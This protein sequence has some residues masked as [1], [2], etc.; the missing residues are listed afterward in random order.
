MRG[1]TPRL[2]H[3]FDK[4]IF[5]GGWGVEPHAALQQRP[6]DVLQNSA[7]YVHKDVIISFQIRNQIERQKTRFK[8]RI[9]YLK[10]PESK[11]RELGFQTSLLT[12]CLCLN[13][14]KYYH[15]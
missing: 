15:L 10:Q 2:L 7:K 14:K 12:L 13:L 1:S 5:A 4:Y 6:P 11:V 8:A 9:T 3:A